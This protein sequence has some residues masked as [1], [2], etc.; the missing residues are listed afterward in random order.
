MYSLYVNMQFMSCF[1]PFL[2]ILINF[3][4]SIT[5]SSFIALS[6]INIRTRNKLSAGVLIIRGR[7]NYTRGRACKKNQFRKF[8]AKKSH[9]AENC[10]KNCR[11]VP[12]LSH[13]ISFYIETNYRMLLLILIH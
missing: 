11:T 12:K 6:H 1:C 8:F 2:Y 10:A 3:S 5:Q 7:N 9:S 13:S 4:Q